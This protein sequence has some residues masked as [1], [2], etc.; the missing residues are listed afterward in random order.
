MGMKTKSLTVKRENLEIFSVKSNFPY[1]SDGQPIAARV[2]FDNSHKLSS[3]RAQ[4]IDAARGEK[5][6]LIAP[7]SFNNAAVLATA[8]ALR[9]GETGTVAI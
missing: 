4:A 6:L 2:A 5:Y 7:I 3:I 8:A 1:W 9:V